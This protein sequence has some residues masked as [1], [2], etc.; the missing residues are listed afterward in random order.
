MLLEKGYRVILLSRQAARR[1]SSADA[2]RPKG[3]VRPGSGGAARESVSL[4]R[5]AHW[6]PRTGAIDAQAVGEADFIVHLA[7]AGV[8]DKRW[9]A[10]RKKEIVDSRTQSSALLVKAL[11]E[12]PNKVQAV[13]SISGI[14]WYGPDP[15]IPNP[16]PFEE[17]DPVDGEFLGET[18]RLWEE[19]ITP[20]TALG[21]RLVIFRTGLVLS[22]KG[23]ALA[24]FKKPIH[25]GVAAI[26]GS[27]RQ[28]V[29]WIHIEDLGR[30]FLQA[31]EEPTWSGV[32]NAVAP[33]PVDNKALTLSLAKRLKGRYFVPVY[34]PTFLLKWLVGELSIEVLKSA[35]VSAKKTREAGFQ[36]IFPSLDGALEDLLA[37]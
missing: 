30:L 21:K 2:S 22:E 35:T 31:I 17:T 37:R 12:I 36:F 13:V 8:A 19:A 6:D 26:L 20:V 18:C 16:R 11:R 28:V 1:G 29:S 32:Y 4:C 14:G 25:L 3:V 27:G 34:V 9:T 33:R 23:G 5:T 15:A 7:G 24:E 10:K